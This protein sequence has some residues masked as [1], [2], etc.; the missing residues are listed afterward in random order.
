MY[1]GL[2]FENGKYF[3]VLVI[4]QYLRA[5][6][7]PEPSGN[8]CLEVARLG[9]ANQ[10]SGIYALI[11]YTEKYQALPESLSVYA[12]SMEDESIAH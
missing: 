6:I 9:I 10:A 3:V 11:I 8:S 5:L 1:W 7:V 12:Q 2:L 4:V